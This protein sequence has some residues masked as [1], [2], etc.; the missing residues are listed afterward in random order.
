M[1]VGSGG[2]LSSGILLAAIA[3]GGGSGAPGDSADTTPAPVTWTAEQCGYSDPGFEEPTNTSVTYPL[4]PGCPVVVVE[5]GSSV[6]TGRPR[7][8]VIVCQSPLTWEEAREAGL[9][10]ALQIPDGIA[11][12]MEFRNECVEVSTGEPMWTGSSQFFVDS[13]QPYESSEGGITWYTAQDGRIRTA[14]VQAAGPV[15]CAGQALSVRIVFGEPLFI[16]DRRYFAC[17]QGT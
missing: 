3:C 8:E 9:I 15:V 5:G 11:P 17:E 13:R 4:I 16:P 2:R 6:D 12:G 1:G 10:A 7:Y 14:Y